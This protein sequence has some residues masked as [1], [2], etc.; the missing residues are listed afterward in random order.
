MVSVEGRDEEVFCKAVEVPELCVYEGV[1][2]CSDLV[3]SLPFVSAFGSGHEGYAV[4]ILLDVSVCIG[5]DL[6][7]S[8]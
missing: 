8:L 4:Q 1:H 6:N 5:G 3:D 2:S 7:F